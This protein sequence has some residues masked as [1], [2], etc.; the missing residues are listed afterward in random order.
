MKKCHVFLNGEKQATVN[1]FSGNVCFEKSDTTVFFA[2]INGKFHL[3][4]LWNKPC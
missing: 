1:S 2:C 3:V 4:K